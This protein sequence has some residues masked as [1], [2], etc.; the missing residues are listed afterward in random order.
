M[1]AIA[2]VPSIG[3]YNV[4]RMQAC[5]GAPME[6]HFKSKNNVYYYILSVLVKPAE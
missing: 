2:F 3:Y 4:E 6:V 5:C 1:Y